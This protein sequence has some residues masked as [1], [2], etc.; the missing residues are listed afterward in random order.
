[1]KLFIAFCLLSFG[2]SAQTK[3]RPNVGVNYSYLTSFASQGKVN[4]YVHFMDISGGIRIDDHIFFD[5]GLGVDL[6]P[7]RSPGQTIQLK[8]LTNSLGINVRILKSKYIFSPMM[9]VNF[10]YEIA[11]YAK[12]KTITMD[13]FG[14]INPSAMILVDNNPYDAY[15]STGD[16]YTYNKMLYFGRAKLLLDV[17]LKNINIRAGAH[18]NFTSFNFS[19]KKKSNTRTEYVYYSLGFEVGALYNFQMKKKSTQV[20]NN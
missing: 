7:K 18:F 12:G 15:N 2:L 8:S 3:L 19:P 10:G 16:Y 9:G 6:G 20:E 1:M 14:I 11:S 17:E 4:V 13:P 5:L